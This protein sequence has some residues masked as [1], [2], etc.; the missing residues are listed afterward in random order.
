MSKS[1]IQLAEAA[2]TPLFTT[3]YLRSLWSA[4]FE[5]WRKSEEAELLRKRLRAWAAKDWQ[6]ETSAEG[7]FVHVFFFETWGYRASGQVHEGEGYTL[8]QQFAVKNAGQGGGTG[9]A[10]VALGHFGLADQEPIPQVLGEFKDDRSGLDKEQNRVSRRSPVDQCFDYLREARSGLVS[11]VLP[12]WAFVS[13]MNEFRLYLYG[14]KAQYQRFVITPAPGDPAV[15][16]TDDSDEAEFQRY[17]FSRVFSPEMLLAPAGKSPLEK[18]LGEQL[19]HERVLEA[20]FYKEYQAYREHL[21]QA[22]RAAN[23]QYAEEQRLRR[24]VGL[25]QRL[26]DRFIFILYCEDM[27]SEL[28]FPPNL[29]RDILIEVAESRFYNDSGT[30]AWDQVRA[31]F[32]TMRDGGPFGKE[33]IHKFNGGL[34]AED[35]EFDNLRV[36]NHVFCERN[37]GQVSG[38]LLNNPLTLLFFSAKY[39]FGAT[40]DGSGKT[41]TLTAMG[42]IFEQSIT[43][44]EVMEAHAAGRE[45]LAE[46]TKRKRDGVYYTPEWVT[47]YIV[48]ETV[49]R[50]LAEIREELGFERIGVVS[51]EQIAIHRED[52]RKMPVVRDYEHALHAYSERLDELKVVDPAC[53]SGAFL[54]QAFQFLYEQR[55]WVAAELE[56]VTGARSLFDTHEAMRAVLANNLYGVDI[57]AESI[58]ITRLALWLHTALP[59]RPLTSLDQNIRCGNSLVSTDFLEQLSRTEADMSADDLERVN[60]FCWEEAFPEVFEREQ[61]GFDCVIGNPPYVKLQNFRRVLEDQAEYLLN[62]KKRDGSPRYESTQTGNFDIYLPFIERGVELLNTE[63][64]LG[65]IAPSVWL[66]NEYG[67]GLRRFVKRTRSLDRWIDFKSYQVFDEATTY[68]ALQF[69]GGKPQASFKCVFAPRGS[70]DVASSDWATPDANVRFA[71]LNEGQAWELVRGAE[72]AVFDKLAGSG[73]TLESE[74][75]RI[76]QGVITSADAIYHLEKI[77]PGRYVSFAQGRSAPEEVELEDEIMLPLIS[78]P[79]V[80]RYEAPRTNTYILFPYTVADGQSALL[81][82]VRFEADFPKALRYLRRYEGQLRSR[83]RGKFDDSSWYRFG[84]NQSIDKQSEPKLCVAQTVPNLRLC[85]DDAGEFCIN[86]VRVNGIL[87]DSSLQ[88]WFLLAVLNAP[89]ADFVFRRIAKPKSGG[90]FEANKQFIAP[91]PVPK[92][93]DAERAEVAERAKR[94]QELHTRRRDLVLKL[95]RRLE[96]AQCVD[97]KREPQW[98]WAEVKPVKELKKLAPKGRSAREKTRWAKDEHERLLGEQLDG[99]D[100][101]L[102]VGAKLDAELRDDELILLI[103]GVPAIEGIFFVDD[104]EARFVAAQWRHALRATNVTEKFDGK[105]LLKKLLELRTSENPAILS[106][107]ITFDDELRSLD[108]EIAAAEEEMN[109]LIYGLYGLSDAEIRLIEAG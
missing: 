62:A 23:P 5:K 7:T 98:L 103:N 1:N 77:G 28:G 45:S 14:N 2:H 34:F 95:E 106:Q 51:D 31:L 104:E 91:L 76:F 89:A 50:R 90:Y 52:G 48:E 82:S 43:D 8:Q 109:A 21:Y 73:L 44:L 22:L 47:A 93:S 24:L 32:A 60:P 100:V 97:D 36:P 20:D 70:E 27:G 35:P 78:G 66:V 6:K 46:I 30:Q 80:K 18:L 79:D 17:L 26:L 38:R 25:T 40:D 96:S 63:G 71:D 37:Q 13:D 102:Q 65:Y 29:L 88:A 9:G 85:Y 49:G 67:E 69:F 4:D 81:E 15:A 99:L 101:M 39:N 92:A 11:K 83:E 72:R 58:E 19:I 10:D 84:R 105:R 54:I 57:N 12:T 16:L 41:L 55:Q 53:G 86:N 94:L 108:D 68:T 3:A 74:T 107:V 75:E 33:R 42:R 64:K 56:R 59:D 87:T 61:S